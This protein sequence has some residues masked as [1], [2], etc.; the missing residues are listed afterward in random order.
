MNAASMRVYAAQILFLC[1]LVTG[2]WA[3][4]LR[5][6][7]ERLEELRAECAVQQV[8]ISEFETAQAARPETGSQALERIAA[9]ND[10]MVEHLHV[11]SS[12][13]LIY[14]ALR[15][16][17]R[18]NGVEIERIEPTRTNGA[19]VGGA[20]SRISASGHSIKFSGTYAAAAEFIQTVQEQV[21]MTKVTA[22]RLLPSSE[23]TDPPRIDA[24]IDA[25]HYGLIERASV[26][27]IR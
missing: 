26:K 9:E 8:Q 13:S 27:G 12:T 11:S 14:D 20:D 24:R 25:T 4:L 15:D 23:P 22:L 5:P 3:L 1:A 7:K 16:L 17:A 21:G 19:R 10:A 18:E 6:M 2:C